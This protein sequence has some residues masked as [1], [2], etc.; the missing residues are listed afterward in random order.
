MRGMRSLGGSSKAVSIFR[1]ARLSSLRSI[2]TGCRAVILPRFGGPEVL[3]LR[4]N[5][6]VPNL[7]PNEIR[8]GYGRSVFQP[9][10]PIIIGRDVSGE[11][12]AVGNS[13]KSF[14]VGQEVFGALHPTALR[15]TYTDYGILS[16]E[17]LTEKP[18]S[19]SHVEA[20]AI[21][22]A[23]LTAWRA[24]KSN[25]RILEGQRVLVFGGG[26]A[27]GFAAIQIAVASGCHVTASCVGQTRE[28]ILAAGAEQAVDYTTE[29]ITL[30]FLFIC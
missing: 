25:A 16:E 15:G 22:F 2:F 20:S 1:P 11:V 28:R 29:V 8:A 23:A 4:E 10:L 12:A 30:V 13:V 14:R 3:E 21:P 6:P 7:N 9:H 19:V 26:G 17:E 5:V 27:V 24:L 18:A